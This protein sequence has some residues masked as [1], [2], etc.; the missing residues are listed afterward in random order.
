M[1]LHQRYLPIIVLKMQ[2]TEVGLVGASDPGASLG[3]GLSCSGRES[4]APLPASSIR[5][6]QVT[7]KERDG[8]P[9]TVLPQS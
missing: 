8:T 9:I 7:E 2:G 3:N 6:S 5:Q 4:P 1:E